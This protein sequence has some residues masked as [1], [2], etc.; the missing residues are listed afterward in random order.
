[1]DDDITVTTIHPSGV[2]V[3]ATMHNGIRVSRNYY[4][5]TEAA[6][7]SDFKTQLTTNHNA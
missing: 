2:L 5:Y 6:A 4:G 3:L 7:R 1:M